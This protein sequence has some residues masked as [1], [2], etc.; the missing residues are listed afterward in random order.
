[1]TQ[2]FSVDEG[3]IL[4]G[5]I[6][7][8]VIGVGSYGT[9]RLAPNIH[10]GELAAVKIMDKSKMNKDQM[11]RVKMEYTAMLDLEY[12]QNIID[13]YQV[14]ENENWL[15]II[16][17]Y[18]Q[19]GDL[20]EYLKIKKS[21]KEEEARKFFLQIL[22]AVEYTHKHFYIHRDL[23]LDNIL[24]DNDL[25][26][27]LADWGFAGKWAPG[28]VLYEPFGSLH[29][30]SPEICAGKTYTGPEIDMWSLGVILYAMVAGAL[31]FG[32]EKTQD[33]YRK[34][35]ACQYKIP[36]Y[37]SANLKNLIKSLLEPDSLKRATLFDVRHHTWITARGHTEDI[38]MPPVAEPVI[39]ICKDEPNGSITDT[40]ANDTSIT[41]T[42]SPLSSNVSS[43]EGGSVSRRLS[44]YANSN[45]KKKYSISSLVI[46][47]K[48]S[49]AG[50][51]DNITKT[52]ENT[53]P[54][55]IEGA[56]RI[57][58]NSFTKEPLMIK[59]LKSMLKPRGSVPT[60]PSISEAQESVSVS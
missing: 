22:D 5:Y 11:E 16:M 29:Y 41:P 50:S 46:R 42:D 12:H 15:C 7:G 24:L 57:R 49:L 10:S 45:G 25:N 21:L 9:V 56:K 54:K 44:R 20:L 51:F 3:S 37:C 60:V 48:S 26:V 34:I 52:A 4:C 1:M 32:G 17:Q 38:V 33:I 14:F 28:K 2:E 40:T 36:S 18:A 59:S 19:N 39:P 8:K 31:P 47:L 43:N 30:A 55:R 6:L 23:K 27:L 13:L 35:M 53:S 58:A